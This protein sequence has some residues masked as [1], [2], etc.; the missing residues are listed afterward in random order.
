MIIVTPLVYLWKLKLSGT[1]HVTNRPTETLTYANGQLKLTMSPIAVLEFCQPDKRNAVSMLMWQELPKALDMVTNNECI[2]VLLVR[3]TG[4]VA[5]CAGADISEFEKTYATPESTAQY[6]EAVRV[7]Q[8]QLRHLAQPTIAW[9]YGDCV[10]SG[11]GLALAC[12]LRFAAD[13]ARFGIPPAKLGLAYSVEDT[14]QLVEK[15][16]PAFAKDLLL[17]ARL[18]NAEE[19]LKAGLINRVISSQN[20][21]R[22][23][24]EY[25]DNMTGLSQTSLRTSKRI[26]NAICDES[27][28]DNPVLKELYRATFAGSDLK[29]GYDAFLQKRKPEF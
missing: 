10:G 27:T 12:D 24:L 22:A 3:G 23:V 5:F 11:C 13:N 7:A 4:M 6:I 17:S 20:L 21:E 28:P 18:V 1:N 26:I 29:E 8:Y 19:A 25:A 15:V 14:A 9:I 16:G 2:R